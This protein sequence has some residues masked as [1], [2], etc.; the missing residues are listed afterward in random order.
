MSPDLASAKMERR[1]IKEQL[2][3]LWFFRCDSVATTGSFETFS[4]YHPE[5]VME[6]IQGVPT[7]GVLGERQNPGIGW[8][9][10]PQETTL[11]FP[12]DRE[13]QEE[14]LS[15]LPHGR[16][17]NELVDYFRSLGITPQTI[18]EMRGD[19]NLGIRSGTLG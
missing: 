15:G 1:R 9:S 16:T 3:K 7:I 10:L 17:Y 18:N 12:H 8:F 6:M 19:L 5:R 11:R 14:A 13:A 4:L 2:R